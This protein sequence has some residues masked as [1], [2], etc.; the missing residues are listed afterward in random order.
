MNLYPTSLGKTK[1]D[2]WTKVDVRQARQ[3]EQMSFTVQFKV[4]EDRSSKGRTVGK[5]VIIASSNWGR[6]ST[7]DK[8]NF[9]LNSFGNF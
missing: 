6:L 5:V 9:T 8:K 1:N 2:I 3:D 7:E 4:A